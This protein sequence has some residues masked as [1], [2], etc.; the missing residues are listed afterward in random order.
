VFSGFNV[1]QLINAVKIAGNYLGT[2]EYPKVEIRGFIKTDSD[3]DRISKRMA[4][5][6]KWLSTA[7]DGRLVRIDGSE[8]RFEALSPDIF[9]KEIH[10]QHF[11]KNTEPLNVYKAEMKPSEAYRLPKEEIFNAAG[12]ECSQ[13]ED[14]VEIVLVFEDIDKE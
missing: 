4:A 3:K 14:V 7:S 13:L 9:M 2:G 10:E 11:T 5:V 1:D 6:K 8:D 12:F